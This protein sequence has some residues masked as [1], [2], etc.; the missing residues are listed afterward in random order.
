MLLMSCIIYG[1]EDITPPQLNSL[2]IS[3][4]YVDVTEGDQIVTI[5]IDISDDISGIHLVNG[6]FYSPSQI[7]KGFFLFV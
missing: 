6:Y 2:I 3:N 4:S 7:Y 1:Q 5:T